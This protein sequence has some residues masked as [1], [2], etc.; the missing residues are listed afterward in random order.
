MGIVEGNKPAQDNEWEEITRGG[1]QAIKRWIESQMEGRTCVVV[2]IGEKTWERKWVQYEIK[3]GWERGMGLLGVYIHTLKDRDG[4]PAR[5]GKNP[6]AFADLFLGETSLERIVKAYDP[7][8]E[9]NSLDSQLWYQYIK[10]HLSE[11]I[12]EAIEIRQKYR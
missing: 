6:F 5:R 1:E 10:K 7:Q 11:W 9:I 4:K 2:L 8:I 3:R 12:E